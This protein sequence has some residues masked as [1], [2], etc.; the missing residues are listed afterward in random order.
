MKG[1]QIEK[2]A[3]PKTAGRPTKVSSQ[4]LEDILTDLTSGFSREEA[5]ARHGISVDTLRQAEKNPK[6]GELR[7]RTRAARKHALLRRIEASDD[8]R[9]AA[10][11]L[12]RNYKEEFG[13]DS[14]LISVRSRG[15]F[16]CAR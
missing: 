9:A 10:W 7:A 13:R 11:L 14:C 1:D 15:A 2:H 12:E 5:C 6:F 8:W 3:C 4:L 16:P